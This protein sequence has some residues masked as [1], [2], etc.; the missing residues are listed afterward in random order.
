[1]EEFSVLETKKYVGYWELGGP[2]GLQIRLEDRPEKH[3]QANMEWCFGI[4]WV[5]LDDND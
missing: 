2:M 5:D 4:V 3:H 1:M